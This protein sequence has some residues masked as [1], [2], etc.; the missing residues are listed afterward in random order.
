MIATIHTFM[1]ALLTPEGSLATLN[2]WRVVTTPQGAPRLHRSSRFAEAEIVHGEEHALLFLPLDAEAVLSVERTAGLLRR[3]VSPWLL[4]YRILPDEL[5]WC[6]TQMQ[7]QRSDLLF[8]PLPAGK[9]L[10]EAVASVHGAA[11]LAAIDRLEEELRRVG[12][13]H[14][15][16]KISNLRWCGD[17]IVPLRYHDA[18]IGEGMADS[19]ETFEALR[20]YV[21]ERTN[22]AEADGKALETIS[23]PAAAG[24]QEAYRWV[25][26][27]FEGMICVENEA[28]YGYVNP[29]GEVVIEPRFLWAGDFHEGR[30]AVQTE[31][32]MGLIDRTGACILSPCYEIVEYD[33]ATSISLVRQNGLWARFDHLGRPLCAFGETEP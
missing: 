32:G 23:Q 1:Q 11:L 8:Q 22:C 2:G 9:P 21:R 12:F 10:S 31:S 19:P 17:R 24:W 30:A 15:N 14:R 25:G 5:V 28:G 20:R 26:N 27:C 33:P 3:I 18:C 4:P 13:A 16:L 7:Q 29:D 6:D